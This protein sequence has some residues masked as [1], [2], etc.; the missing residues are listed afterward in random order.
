MKLKC[1]QQYYVRYLIKYKLAEDKNTI[2]EKLKNFLGNEDIIKLSDNDIN[3]E[4]S[5]ISK[6]INDEN[7]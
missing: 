7:I 5:L 3:Y 2:V 1:N 6:K 4:K